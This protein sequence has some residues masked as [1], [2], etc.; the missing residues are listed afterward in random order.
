M[1]G[2]LRLRAGGGGAQEARRGG[3][4]RSPAS[5]HARLY[6]TRAVEAPGLHSEGIRA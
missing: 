4:E 5:A 1:L 3:H 2:P 6:L